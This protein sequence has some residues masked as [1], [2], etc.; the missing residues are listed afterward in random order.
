MILLWYFLQQNTKSIIYHIHLLINVLQRFFK[1]RMILWDFSFKKNYVKFCQA[2]IYH[3][4]FRPVRLERPGLRASALYL[5]ATRRWPLVQGVWWLGAL[6]LQPVLEPH[7]K[8]DSPSA[9]A[10]QL[11]KMKLLFV[12]FLFKKFVLSKNLC[13]FAATELVCIPLELQASH[14]FI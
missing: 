13:I 12:I 6:G 11:Y 9:N 8:L 10:L 2:S 1:S 3:N 5:S 7:A 4:W 14:F